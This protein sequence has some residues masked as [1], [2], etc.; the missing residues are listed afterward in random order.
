[1]QKS[2]RNAIK[3]SRKSKIHIKRRFTKRRIVK[4]RNVKRTNVKG[5]KDN[6]QNILEDNKFQNTILNK[7]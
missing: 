4:R 1:M 2:K 3:K 6:S 7:T 5:G